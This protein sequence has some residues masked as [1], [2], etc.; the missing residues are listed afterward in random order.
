[1]IGASKIARDISERI[2]AQEQQELLHGE[3]KNRIKNLST[4]IDALARQSRP[5]ND[6]AVAAFFATFVGRLQA[7]LS[8]GALVLD[9]RS[10][11]ADLRE[12]VET[13]LEPFLDSASKSRVTIGGPA[14]R[15]GEQTAGGLTLAFHELA[16]NALKYGALKTPQGSVTVT[17]SIAPGG[18]GERAS[19]EWKE[20]TTQPVAAPDSHGF[21][22][23]VIAAAVANELDSNSD[24]QFEPDG[25]RCRFEFTIG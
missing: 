9:S 7:L 4:V 10:R 14:L 18:T 11:R 12:I 22:S 21:G 25:V 13:A 2:R 6:P 8:T 20:H 1:V 17:W 3:M 16:T 24:L 19:I 5:K 23:R 15:V